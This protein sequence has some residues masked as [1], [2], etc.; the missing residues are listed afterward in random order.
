MYKY[1]KNYE[2]HYEKDIEIN[3]G[4]LIKAGLFI[5][6]LILIVTTCSTAINTMVKKHGELTGMNSIGKVVS[7]K[8]QDSSLVKKQHYRVAY[9]AYKTGINFT[10]LDN[11][12]LNDII[13]DDNTDTPELAKRYFTWKGFTSSKKYLKIN[14]RDYQT[15]KEKGILSYE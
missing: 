9:K 1:E 3:G 12:D 7:V 10:K 14:K 11:I 5:L 15:L 8:E 4:T 2:K 13:I 6:F